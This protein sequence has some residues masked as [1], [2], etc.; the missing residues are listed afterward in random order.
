MEPL[1]SARLNFTGGGPVTEV[2]VKEGQT[3][4]AGEVI[5][6]V[7]SDAQRNALTE[8]EAVLAAAKAGQAA[9]RDQYNTHRRGA[10]QDQGR[11]GA[12]IGRRRRTR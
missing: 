2:L 4:Q 12:A 10:E 6:R 7:K 8:A 1:Q 11:S 9:Y 3:V 5:A